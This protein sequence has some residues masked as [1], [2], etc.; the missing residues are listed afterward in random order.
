MSDEEE[1]KSA[2]LKVSFQATS[3]AHKDIVKQIDELKSIAPEHPIK[4]SL[5]AGKLVNREQ[6][7]EAIVY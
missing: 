1:G 7:N 3:I 6:G 5:L 4:M 2:S